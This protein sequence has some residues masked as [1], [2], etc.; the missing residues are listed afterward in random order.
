[1]IKWLQ[2]LFRLGTRPALE[3]Y[4]MVEFLYQ[5]RGWM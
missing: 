5:H 2:R 4:R 3:R 1:M